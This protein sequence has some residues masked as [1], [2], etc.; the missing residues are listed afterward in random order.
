MYDIYIDYIAS[1]Y[2]KKTVKKAMKK[3]F[4]QKRREKKI[5]H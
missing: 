4:F 2:E 1:A 3:N 5:V